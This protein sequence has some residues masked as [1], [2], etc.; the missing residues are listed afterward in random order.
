MQTQERTHTNKQSQET[1][2]FKRAGRG[3]N[4]DTGANQR[5]D[6]ASSFLG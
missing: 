3:E 5:L 1:M 2:Q 4:V 6:G